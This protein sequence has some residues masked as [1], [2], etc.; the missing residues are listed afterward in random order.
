[1]S[2]T[3]GIRLVGY[4]PA[5]EDRL[6]LFEDKHELTKEDV[7]P[8]SHYINNDNPFLFYQTPFMSLLFY[9][10][11]KANSIWKVMISVTQPGRFDVK[12]KLYFPACNAKIEKVFIDKY[13]I[14]QVT[15]KVLV[16]FT[17]NC[18]LKITKD[19][20]FFKLAHDF[21]NNKPLEFDEDDFEE[22]SIEVDAI[23]AIKEYEAWHL[24]ELTDV[25]YS[26]ALKL[27]KVLGNR[28]FVYM[29]A[30]HVIGEQLNKFIYSNEIKAILA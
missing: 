26:A 29:L 7:I 30:K 19:D 18:A 8:K 28:Q 2:E 9:A 4:A 20:K 21:F 25:A 3:S 10:K 13:R 23:R 11:Y 1:M 12:D 24:E 27:N 22:G 15:R 16:P 17:V 14:H 5:R 6:I